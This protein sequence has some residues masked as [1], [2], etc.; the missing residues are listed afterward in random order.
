MGRVA[1]MMG[2]GGGVITPVELTGRE[3]ADERD[4]DGSMMKGALKLVVSL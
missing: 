4:P 2:E 3:L 1:A